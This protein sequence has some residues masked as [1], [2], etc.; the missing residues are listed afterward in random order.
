MASEGEMEQKAAT[1]TSLMQL[2]SKLEKDKE[3]ALQEL[4]GKQTMDVTNVQQTHEDSRNAAHE[5]DLARE[6]HRHQ[7]VGG[8]P[9]SGVEVRVATSTRR[10][11]P[12][13][14][15]SRPASRPTPRAT[16]RTSTVAGTEYSAD[17]S[18]ADRAN[19]QDKMQLQSAEKDVE[20]P[21]ARR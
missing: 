17:S 12:T 18:S 8:A 6:Q 13:R 9:Q 15:S 16:R 7:R 10:R 5:P 21:A 19:G 14:T 11:R 3:M 20:A 1:E 4:R 2:K